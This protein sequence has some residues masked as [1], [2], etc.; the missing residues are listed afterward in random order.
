MDRE[1]LTDYPMGE[2]VVTVIVAEYVHAALIEWTIDGRM[3]PPVRHLGVLARTV[4][5]HR[6]GPAR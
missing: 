1:G 4:E 3:R 6:S 2:Y 5:A